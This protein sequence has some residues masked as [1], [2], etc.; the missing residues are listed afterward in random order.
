MIDHALRRLR[1]THAIDA[2]LTRGTVEV[3][4]AH[5]IRDAD[6]VDAELARIAIGV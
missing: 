2:E 1:F 5:L 3:V 6:L 4:E